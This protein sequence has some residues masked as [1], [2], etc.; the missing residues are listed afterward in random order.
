MSG[1]PE[2]PGAPNTRGVRD[3]VGP[4]VPATRG[5]RGEAELIARCRQGDDEA[6]RELVDQHKRLVFA[7]IARSVSDQAR[8]EELSQEVFLRVH[9]G[10]AYFRGDA[11]LSTWIYRIV[12]NVVVE[13]RTR[14]RV[15]EISLDDPVPG[16]DLPRMDPGAEDRTFGDLELRDRLQKA[17]ERLPVQ[18]QL[19]VNGHYLEGMRYEDL[20]ESLQLPLGTVKTHL[21]RAKRLLR[22]ML[23]GP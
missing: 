19:L 23:E 15:V 14:R 4:V 9:R 22:L 2:R 6:F 16:R 21:H 12:C 10:L 5:G 8:A 20:A 13:E 3:G 11:R 7:L 1:I 17:V 18:Y